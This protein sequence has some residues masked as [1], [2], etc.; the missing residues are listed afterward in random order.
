MKTFSL[1]WQYL[2]EL[3]FKWEMFQTTVADKIKIHISYSVTFS[4]KI[5]SFM[6]KCRKMWLSQRGR[7]WK[8]GGA[9][10]DGLVRLHARKHTP[11]PVHPHPHQ[12]MHTHSPARAITHTHTHTHT[13]TQICNNYCFSTAKMVPWTRLNVRLYVH[14]L[15]YFFRNIMLNCLTAIFICKLSL[16]VYVRIL[17]VLQMY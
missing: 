7:R 5:V 17:L 1:L 12:H 14:C 6:T 2:A 15:S 11:A 9:L 4:P 13:H 8:N 3:F 10:Y 16:Y